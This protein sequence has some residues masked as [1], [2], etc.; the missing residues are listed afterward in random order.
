MKK[1]FIGI[2]LILLAGISFSGCRTIKNEVLPFN[3]EILIYELP[4][5]LTY[6]R[7]MEALQAV[8]DW[9]LEITDKEKGLI[10]VRNIRYDSFADADLRTIVLE[11]HRVSRRETSVKI[12]RGSQRVPGG[13]KLL[14]K[15]NEY[16]TR[17][18]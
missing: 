3:D 18:L 9:E 15:I 12:A 11:L 14:K 1:T 10:Q 17:E 8:R 2:G 4:F 6:L 13:D 7:T 5:D 16:L